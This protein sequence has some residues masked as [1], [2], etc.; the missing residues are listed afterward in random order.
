A[1]TRATCRVAIALFRCQP[2]NRG[3][4]PMISQLIKELGVELSHVLQPSPELVQEL[5]G[6]RYGVFHVENAV[7]SP[8]IP[9]QEDF[10]VRHGIRSVVGFGGMLPS[11][12]LFAV[13]LFATVHVPLSAAERF[14]TIALDVKSAFSRFGDENVFAP[15]G[16]GAVEGIRA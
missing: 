6:K 16:A 3:K 14:K 7:G 1:G 15:F 11:G 8:Y 5:A 13:I 2:R 4:A 10:V 12:D 9:V